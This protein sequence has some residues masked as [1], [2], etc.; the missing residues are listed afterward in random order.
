MPP[1]R[2]GGNRNR[3]TGRNAAACDAAGE[4]GRDCSRRAI[5]WRGENSLAFIRPW[6]T[7]PCSAS[8]ADNASMPSAEAPTRSHRRSGSGIPARSRGASSSGSIT[9]PRF[10]M[11]PARGR[12]LSSAHLPTPAGPGSFPP[13]P[14]PASPQVQRCALPTRVSTPRRPGTRKRRIPHFLGTPLLYQT[15]GILQEE[16]RGPSPGSPRAVVNPK[17]SLPFAARTR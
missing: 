16:N 6:R 8:P 4:C 2:K 3:R 12:L 17:S 9:G 10:S 7:H 15:K 13:E 11:P 5:Q 1:G 14:A